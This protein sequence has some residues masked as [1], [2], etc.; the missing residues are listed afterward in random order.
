METKVFNVGVKFGE[1]AVC[2]LAVP[3]IL[4]RS[5]TVR[6]LVR[7]VT[8]RPQPTEVKNHAARV[9]RDVMNKPREQSRELNIEL[10]KG[11]DDHIQG[12]FVGLHDVIDPDALAP[13]TDTVTLHISEPY[14][15]G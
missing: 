5:M 7:H 8:S 13:I 6:N 14:I 1:S 9:V 10:I 12:D 2:S 11:R 15:G 4:I 3:I